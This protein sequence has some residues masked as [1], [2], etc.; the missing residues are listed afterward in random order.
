MK[1]R[2]TNRLNEMEIF[3]QVINSGSFSAAA[4]FLQ[5]CPSAISK[6]ILRMENRLGVKLVNRSTR[7]LVLTQ[8]GEFYYQKTLKLLLELDEID[9]AIH[10]QSTQGKV[11]MTCSIP[12]ALH[13]FIPLL[14]QFSAVH[15]GIEIVLLGSDSIVDLFSHRCDIAIRIGNLADSTLKMRKLAESKMIL[16]ASPLYLQQRNSPNTF[17]DLKDHICLNFLGHPELNKW[18]FKY[19]NDLS[20]WNAQSFFSADNGE[21]ILKMVE[22]GGGIARLSAFMVRDKINSGALIP[23]LENYNSGEWQS[24]YLLHL[25]KPAARVRKVIDFIFE[26]LGKKRFI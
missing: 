12:F 24:I 13:Q 14:P 3:K 16:V 5:M 18:S 10:S 22:S 2:N 7:K 17:M 11:R 4:K 1:I 21:S 19:K 26:K 23:L 9:H 25:G 6:I 20:H 8:E 15:P